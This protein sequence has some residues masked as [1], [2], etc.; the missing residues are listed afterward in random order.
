[1]ALTE[2]TENTNE[3]KKE[4]SKIEELVLKLQQEIA[5]LKLKQSGEP[6]PQ[7]STVGGLSADQFQVFMDA[8]TNTKKKDLD[9]EEG[10]DE[11][12]IPVD[13]FEENGV[14]FFVPS[15]GYVM[16]CDRRKG[17]IVKLPWGKKTIFFE[18]EG[19][20]IRN[21][22]KYQ[23]LS[24]ISKYTSYS[25]KEIEWIRNHSMYGVLIYENT[26]TAM[27]ADM[28]KVQRM[29]KVIGS[30]RAV[31]HI[32][33]LK[34]CGAYNVPKSNDPNEM[35]FHIA[36]EMVNREFAADNVRTNTM[37]NIASKESLLSEA[38]K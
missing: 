30:L 12:Q 21:Q 1:M 5:D 33:L 11:S 7:Q 32:D 38:K 16:S 29:S 27:N 19:T 13:D 6:M 22:G 35:R 18:H 8:V 4:P 37:L 17:K 34:M 25:K 9:F 36:H 3:N 20:K 10:V 23:E 31:D 2:G 24:I 26:N 14:S 28:M 15:T